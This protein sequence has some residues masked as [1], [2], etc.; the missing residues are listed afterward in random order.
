LYKIYGKKK[1]LFLH[2]INIED[3]KFAD[4]K[5]TGEIRY[6]GENSKYNIYFLEFEGFTCVYA[7]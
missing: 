7:F 2:H 4:E 3:F 1:I 5:T 6:E